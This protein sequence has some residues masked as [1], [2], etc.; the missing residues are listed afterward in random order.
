[1]ISKTLAKKAGLFFFTFNFLF[2]RKLYCLLLRYRI[3]RALRKKKNPTT[4]QFNCVTYKTSSDIASKFRKGIWE[5]DKVIPKWRRLEN[6]VREGEKIF[7]FWYWKTV[8]NYK[9]KLQSQLVRYL[10]VRYF[11]IVHTLSFL[12][13][14]D[15]CSLYLMCSF[16]YGLSFCVWTMLQTTN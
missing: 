13:A 7:F 4:S 6:L 2:F 14:L 1:M 10:G 3:S 9:V 5:L 11:N 8:S 12:R 16:E 15:V